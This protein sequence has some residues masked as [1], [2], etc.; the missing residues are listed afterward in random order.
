MPCGDPF[1]SATAISIISKRFTHS[2]KVGR[3]I[4]LSSIVCIERLLFHQCVIG[5]LDCSKLFCVCLTTFSIGVILQDEFSVRL[6]Y[7]GFIS[8]CWYAQ[9][10]V[11]TRV[12]IWILNAPRGDK[13]ALTLLKPSFGFFRAKAKPSA[14]QKRFLQ[15]NLTQCWLNLSH[16]AKHQVHLKPWVWVE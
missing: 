9:H 4:S 13:G 7:L 10:G 14:N 11:I 3:F 2:A 5:F 15:F 6:L 1:A 12:M 8:I 16:S